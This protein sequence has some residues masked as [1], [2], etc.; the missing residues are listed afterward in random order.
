MAESAGLAEI[1][2]QQFRDN[3]EKQVRKVHEIEQT[4]YHYTGLPSLMGM[5][6]TNQ[7]W[8]SK[9]TFLNDS[10]ELIYFSRVLEFVVRKLENRKHTSL[11]RLYIREL[12]RI[13]GHFMEEVKENGF[14]VYIF[15]LSRAQDSLALWYNY[16]KGEGY[17]IGFSAEQLFHKVS[18][19]STGPMLHGYVMYGRQEQEEVLIELLQKTFE[20]V[21]PYEV[22][23]IQKAL[24][25]HF[26]SLIA[27]CAVFFK[28]PAFK[29]EEEYRIALMSR[30]SDKQP[31]VQFRAQNGVIIPYI[32]IDF[33]ARLPISHI[34]IG[35]KNNVDIAQSGMEHYLK[36][37]G[38]DMEQ[39]TISKSVA[40]LR[41]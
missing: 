40:A 6:E 22:E 25:G 9:G 37:K 20:L 17:N 39:V 10:S 27:S 21:E 33:Q 30:K 11:W 3:V 24:P 38:Y 23:E 28:D 15:S 1:L 13:M 8:M 4:L 7:L 14:E 31:S 19:F 41:Y 35:P 16:A 12:E 26:F 29:S 32:S 34:T 2:E 18:G 36:W 5:I